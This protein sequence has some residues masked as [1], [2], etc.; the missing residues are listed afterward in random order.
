MF[1]VQL[2]NVNSIVLSSNAE[3]DH[4]LVGQ[5]EEQTDDGELHCP[6]GKAWLEADRQAITCSFLQGLPQR[7]ERGAG[8]AGLGNPGSSY[9]IVSANPGC[10]KTLQFK[11]SIFFKEIKKKNLNKRDYK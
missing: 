10:E 5:G 2:S 1:S 9:S 8:R 4:S 11:R 6:G 7:E 3:Y